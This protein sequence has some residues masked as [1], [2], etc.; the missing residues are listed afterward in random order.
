[1]NSGSAANIFVLIDALGWP[2]VEQ[3]EFLS[4][5]LPYRMP[6][7]TVLG[8]SSGAVPTI[9]T[10][11]LPTETGHWNLFYYDPGNSPFRWLRHFSFLPDVILGHRVT[12]KLLKELGR[13]VL[14]QGPL[15]ECA[16]SPRFLPWLNWVEK[17]NL[18]ASN[19][20][21]GLPTIFDHLQR[22]GIPYRVYSYHDCSDAEVLRRAR[23]DLEQSEASFFFLYLSEMDMFLHT[24]CCDLTAVKQRLSWYADELRA[25]HDRARARHPDSRLV[26]F[27]DHGMTPVRNSYDV[28]GEVDSLGW[29]MPED[30]LAVYDS[31]M[32]RFWIFSEPARRSIVERLA[33]LG[34]GRIL[35]DK[36]LQQLGVFFPD[37]RYGDVIFLLH[38]GWLMARSDFNDRRWMP[39]GMH[40]YDPGDPY[41]DA[42]FLSSVV[43][44]L[45][46][47]T[48]ADLYECMRGVLR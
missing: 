8:Y 1:M 47:R 5:V 4:D 23:C 20:V 19:G 2:Y 17:R 37:R 13:H 39:A 6:V 44:P 33:K 9:L 32:A 34:C 14:G 7:R 12:R 42:V 27:S 16:V 36:E 40:G 10:G 31:T 25:L 15:F 26:V 28:F 41:S 3:S 30:Y 11:K 21:S 43:P 45:R 35:T 46:P 18:F 22:Q 24:H 29:R 48:I 38:P